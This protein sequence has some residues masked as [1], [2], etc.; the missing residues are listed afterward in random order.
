MTMVG[1]KGG[2]VTALTWSVLDTSWEDY[3]VGDDGG[4]DQLGEDT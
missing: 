1:G 2:L 4:R 3:V